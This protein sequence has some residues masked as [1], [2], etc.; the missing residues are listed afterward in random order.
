[1]MTTL[2]LALKKEFDLAVDEMTKVGMG[3][4]SPEKSFYSKLALGLRPGG[5]SVPGEP[6]RPVST[7]PD[8]SP[9]VLILPDTMKEVFRLFQEF[10]LLGSYFDGREIDV[11]VFPRA[12]L[13]DL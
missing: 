1:M 4:D 8:T 3:L 2:E 5:D 7:E 9:P 6:P 12:Q 11:R 13:L 10:G